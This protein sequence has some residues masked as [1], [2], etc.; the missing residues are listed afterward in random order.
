MPLLLFP[1]GPDQTLDVASAVSGAAPAWGVTISTGS[2]I[3][4]RSAISA[5]IVPGPT[6]T[7]PAQPTVGSRLTVEVYDGTL[8]AVRVAPSFGTLRGTLDRSRARSFQAELADAGSHSVAVPNP[9]RSPLQ[10]GRVVQYRIDGQPVFAGLVEKL[11]TRTVDPKEE[12]GQFTT[13]T[14]RGHLAALDDAPVLPWRGARTRPVS[15]ARVYNFAAPAANDSWWGYA[16]DTHA[17]D[18]AVRPAAE[19]PYIWPEAW[20]HPS[21]KWVWDRRQWFDGYQVNV[22]AGVCYLRRQF[23]LGSTQE[24]ELFCAADDAYEVWVDG[25]RVLT[26]AGYY[27]GQKQSVKLAMTAGPHLIAA[28][29]EN[30]NYA[31]AGFLSVLLPV[32]LFPVYGDPVL[33][34]DET[35]RCLPY[36]TSTP[37][38]TPG[39]I[40]RD[41]IH[42]AQVVGSVGFVRQS[43]DDY[44]DSDGAVWDVVPEVSFPIG[45]S[46]LDAARTM[47]EGICETAMAPGSFL[48][49]AWRPGGRGTDSGIAFQPAVNVTAMTHTTED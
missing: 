48:L 8:P 23:T 13:A 5:P 38:L 27:K 20:P 17:T 6:V 33:W 35:W 49:R 9:D 44:Y 19:V 34:T 43:F 26:D 25:V 45:S 4:A 47:A 37:G 22:P 24:Y 39:E 16:V 40:W 15:D 31:K 2:R 10:Y 14:G 28:R 21:A 7:L 42:Q 41:L 30:V 3:Q 32:Q 11:T 12:A 1:A 29:V 36:P 46:L 18:L